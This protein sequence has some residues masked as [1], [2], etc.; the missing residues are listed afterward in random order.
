MYFYKCDVTSTESVKVVGEKVRKEHGDPTVLINNAGIG[1]EGPI[2]H[3]PE[4]TIRK[5]F[6]VNTLAHWWTV[7]EFL[8]AMV[9]HNH[10]HIVT[11]ASAASFL[12]LGEMADY[13][14]SKAS[15]LSFHEG[16]TQE[17]RLWY[18]AK[19]V[20]TRLVLHISLY[21]CIFPPNK[22]PY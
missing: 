6:E 5:V 11:I 13:S 1:H 7:R 2:L 3:K 17:I 8:P 21:I 20:R 22:N 10:G 16:L 19:K 14:C 18:K 12:G 15:A 4:G 9:K